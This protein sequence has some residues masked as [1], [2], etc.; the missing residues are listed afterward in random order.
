MRNLPTLILL[1][2]RRMASSALSGGQGVDLNL[3]PVN[4]IERIEVLEDGA[5]ALYGSD[6]IGGV[7]N[8]ITK[9]NYNG[10]EISERIGFPTDSTSD[11]LLQHQTSIL[12]GMSTEN[13]RIVFGGQYYHSNLL[14]EKD[15]VNST[16]AGLLNA[17]LLPTGANVTDETFPGRID[18][19]SAGSY[20]LAGTPLAKGAPGYRPKFGRSPH[21]C[22]GP[23]TTV[24]AYNAAAVTQLGYAPTFL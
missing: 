21:R 20:V 9:K 12:A 17:G 4:M 23:F 22:G 18:D 13:T 7:I 24:T 3:I 15:R 6:A 8:I 16:P 19:V 2:G 10:A 11:H 14:L 1:D 5:S